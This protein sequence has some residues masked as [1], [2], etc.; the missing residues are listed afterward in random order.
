[1]SKGIPVD[2]TNP[3]PSLPRPPSPATLPD[4]AVDSAVK[5]AVS[6]VDVSAVDVSDVDASAATLEILAT[7][8]GWAAVNKPSG[9]LVHNSA[10]AGPPERTLTDLVRE[11]LPDAVPLHRLDR[12]TS[13]VCF[14]AT[15]RRQVAP[16]Q[17]A[18]GRFHPSYLAIVRGRP[19]ATI[20]ID[21]AITDDDARNVDGTPKSR[22]ARSLFVP[23]AA[24]TVARLSLVLVTLETGRR[25]QAR[26]H[27]KHVSHPI[28]GD[29]S[30]G[31]G[32]LN[33]EY[34]AAYGLRRLCLHAWRSGFVADPAGGEGV[35][36]AGAVVEAPL[37]GDWRHALT[38]LWPGLD[39]EDRL[40]SCLRDLPPTAS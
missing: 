39:V 34:A 16:L 32:P 12:G 27:C 1:M 37:P 11:Q 2:H 25:H 14:F 5:G 38:A 28:I 18:H 33:R 29:A 23:I 17:A 13:G 26:R 19:T 7:G 30:Y 20:D 24:S 22:P 9:W 4:T 21:H 36:V 10:W 6:T 40:R 8:P 15:D 35:A 3:P 31:K